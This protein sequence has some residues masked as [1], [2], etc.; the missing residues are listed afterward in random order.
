MASGKKRSWVKKAWERLKGGS[1]KGRSYRP[2]T[3]EILTDHK[4][5]YSAATQS[6]DQDDSEILPA[7][8]QN[9]ADRPSGSR[10][11]SHVKERF[12]SQGF[13]GSSNNRDRK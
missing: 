11:S 7:S 12:L 5:S 1:Q 2:C 6:P 13:S 10:A 8:Q 4:S 9:Q 3:L